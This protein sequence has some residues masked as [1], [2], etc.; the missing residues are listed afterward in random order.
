MFY[1]N[2]MQIDQ[3]QNKENPAKRKR[4]KKNSEPTFK[5]QKLNEKPAQKREQRKKVYR[6]QKNKKLNKLASRLN[7]PRGFQF[8]KNRKITTIID[9]TVYRIFKTVIMLF[10]LNVKD[11]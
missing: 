3:P 4:V 7:L 9:F 11:F 10:M 8:R 6:V 2:L 1:F 5:K